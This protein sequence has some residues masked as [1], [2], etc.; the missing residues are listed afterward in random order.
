MASEDGGAGPRDGSRPGLRFWNR[1]SFRLAGLF[2]LVTVLAVVLVGVVVYGRQKRE[3]ED[4][5]GTQLL[6][7]A[8]IGSLLVD[9][10]L[11]AQAMAAPGSSAYARVQKTLNAIRTEAVLPTPIYTLA[12][13]KGMARVA[14]TGDDGAVAG[15]VYTPAPD[16]AERL[17]WTFEDGVARY[18]GIYRNARGTWI[19]AFAPVGGEAG[20]R[21]AV[22][23]VDYPVEIYLDRLNEL[24]F[25]ILYASM[26]GALAALIVGLVMARR[27]TRPISALTRG[28]APLLE[29]PEGLRFGGEKRVVTILMSD[30]RGYT[31]FAEQG[32]PARVMEVLN[33]YLARMTDIVV[34]HGGTIN[35]FIGDAIF[36]IFGAPIPHADH[37]ERAA[38]TALAMQRAMTEINDT[39][40]ARG[41][42][43]FE[44]G[45]GVNTGE[46][47]VGNIGSEQRAKYAVVGSAVNVAAR[48]EGSTV[49]G[50]VF[51]SAVTY[52]QLRDKAEVL[53]PVSVELKGLAAPLLLYELR[54]LGGRF[55][56]RLPE[57][58]T[59]DEEQRDVALALTC[60]VI[61]GKAVSKE[62]LAGEVVRIGRRGLAARL[63]RPLAPLT[64]VRLRM[65]Y[66]ASGHESAEGHASGDLYG[67][68]TAGGTPT[69]IR[70]TSVDTAD[71]HAIEML[72]HP[73]TARAAGSA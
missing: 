68:V 15:T 53:P 51:L 46:A 56:Q 4:A 33:G 6:N 18:T 38:A 28:V 11:H 54:G 24:Q 20:K 7:I 55:A 30:L 17:G 27:L 10:Q 45:I 12:L 57:A 59:E 65:T 43:R 3:V 26:A 61:D 13:E 69:L 5:V 14:V 52:E 39:H 63:A 71:Q 25:S 37:A 50:Q 64:N 22:L 2:A 32:D 70:L 67:K 58:T 44:M 66:P 8:R 60:W 41:L 21:L 23:V 48:I 36:A 9:A 42:P 19:S 1:L 35:E 31:R 34:E 73:G 49:G 29:S 47:V 40:V 16:V 62:S 72:L